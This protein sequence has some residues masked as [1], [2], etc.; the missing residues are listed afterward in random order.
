MSRGLGDVYKRQKRRIQKPHVHDNAV[1]GKAQYLLCQICCFLLLLFCHITPAHPVPADI[2]ISPFR[3]TG[4]SISF[5]Y[6]SRFY[7]FRTDITWYTLLPTLVDIFSS[8]VTV[9]FSTEREHYNGGF[10]F[11][12]GI[13]CHYQS[14]KGSSYTETPPSS[15]SIRRS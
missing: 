9:S 2:R 5:S 1:S 10:D 12:P 13:L 3:I 14:R 8:P 7:P 11:S 4:L 6:L 15:S